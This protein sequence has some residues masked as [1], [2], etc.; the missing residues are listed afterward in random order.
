MQARFNY[1]KAAPGAFRAMLGLGQYLHE[2]GLEEFLICARP[3]AT[4][5]RTV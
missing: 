5:A 3:R 1:V 4:A 2:C